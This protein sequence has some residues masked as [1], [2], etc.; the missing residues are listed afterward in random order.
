M[1]ITTE[2]AHSPL[3]PTCCG[4]YGLLANGCP[5]SELDSYL[6]LDGGERSWIDALTVHDAGST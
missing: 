4:Q 2:A 1:V 3:L 6:S 5:L